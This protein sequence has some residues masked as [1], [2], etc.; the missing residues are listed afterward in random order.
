M[1]YTVEW[2]L[3]E[4]QDELA[5]ALHDERNVGGPQAPCGEE[6]DSIDADT[7]I[8]NCFCRLITVGIIRRLTNDDRIVARYPEAP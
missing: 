8:P 5:Q 1:N 4:L 2:T 3:H 7:G 6:F